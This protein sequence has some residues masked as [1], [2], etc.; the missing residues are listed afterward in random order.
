VNNDWKTN[1]VY[2]AGLILFIAMICTTIIL[3]VKL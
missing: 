1:A 2:M 3:L